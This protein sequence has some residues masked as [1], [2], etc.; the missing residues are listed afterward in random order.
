MIDKVLAAEV[1][2]LGGPSAAGK[3]LLA[4]DLALSVASGDA[5]QGY[6]VTGAR[7][8]LSLQRWRGCTTWER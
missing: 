4:R 5:W 6:R 1:N 3:S 8:V 7:P 2:L